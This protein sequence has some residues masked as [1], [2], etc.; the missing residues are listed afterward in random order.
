V[1]KEEPR[2][3]KVE[4]SHLPPG[5]Y[6]SLGE[7]PVRDRSH[8]DDQNVDRPR[9]IETWQDIVGPVYRSEEAPCPTSVSAYV[10]DDPVKFFPIVAGVADDG[11]PLSGERIG[12]SATDAATAADD[13][14]PMIL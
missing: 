7:R 10:P 9:L 13:E 14:C 4:F 12:H 6:V 3:Q 11:R 8:R 1:G 5:L 2:Q